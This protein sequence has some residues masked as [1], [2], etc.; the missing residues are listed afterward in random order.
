[1]VARPMLSTPNSIFVLHLATT[2]WWKGAI[3]EQLV[4]TGPKSTCSSRAGFW[5]LWM[6]AEKHMINVCL[7]FPQFVSLLYV[8][9]DGL[10]WHNGM[11]F[12]TKDRDNDNSGDHCARTFKGAWWFN[13]CMHS[14]LNGPWTRGSG[15]AVFISWFNWK[16]AWVGLKKTRMMVRPLRP[17]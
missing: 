15:H 1:M 13:G 10:A 14:N 9:G 17:M 7:C 6:N 12:A 11:Q 5:W 2:P 3:E 16:G 4:S 8:T